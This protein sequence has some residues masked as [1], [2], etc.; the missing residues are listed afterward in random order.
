MV[1]GVL[2]EKTFST[3]EGLYFKLSLE[4][5]NKIISDLPVTIFFKGFITFLIV[6]IYSSGPLL[7]TPKLNAFRLR[8]LEI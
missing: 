6:E 4:K 5:I 8:M 7:E 1:I 3:F 2:E